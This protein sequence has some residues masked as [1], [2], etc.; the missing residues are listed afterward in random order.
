MFAPGPGTKNYGNVVVN[1]QLVGNGLPG[2]AIHGHAPGQVLG[3]FMIVGNYISGNAADTDDAN[4]PGPTGINVFG[5]AAIFGTVIANNVIKDEQVDIAIRTVSPA[6]VDAHL[7]NLLGEQI[8][9]DNL[10]TGTVNATENWWGCAKGPGSAG[11]TSV[12]GSNIVSTPFLTRPSER[13]E[14]QRRPSD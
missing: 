3:D 10:G 14:E 1:N 12:S 8:G 7:N 4:T 5:A 13:A 6:V 9:V 2:V 11:C